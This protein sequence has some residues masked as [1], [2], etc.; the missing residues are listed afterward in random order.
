M[1]DKD[2][3]E[4]ILKQIEVLKKFMAPYIE[5]LIDL[6]QELGTQISNTRL[7][8]ISRRISELV[9]D[10]INTYNPFSVMA[11]PNAYRDGQKFAKEILNLN[12][13][14]NS[15]ITDE[16]TIKALIRDMQHDFNSTITAFETRANF[17]LKQFSKQG[18]LTESEISSLVA[19]GYVNTN[20][21][22][23]A[24]KLL[25]AE[26]GENNLGILDEDAFGRSIKRRLAAKKKEINK[27]TVN[28][29]IRERLLQEEI[30]KLQEG[31]FM[32]IIDKNGNVRTYHVDTYA[33]LVSRTRLGDAQVAGT[34][35]EAGQYGIDTFRVSAHNTSTPK[36]KPF[37]NKIFTTNSSNKKF[38]LLT[39]NTR[40]LYHVNCQHRLLPKPFTNAQLE[41]MV[42]VR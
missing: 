29:E 23:G 4:I 39:E 15:R 5:E 2:L 17:V 12:K 25:R 35:E 37:E 10:L 11:V 22:L 9:L 14:I 21:G 20:T 40:P 13:A 28:Q 30:D 27:I 34:I 42:N 1:K 38:L 3:V 36:C 7:A 19:Q 26:I 33:D 8:I 16:K 18:R 32:Q 41:E 6:M 31:K 24:K